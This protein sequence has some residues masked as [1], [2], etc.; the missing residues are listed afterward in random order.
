MT[1]WMENYGRHGSPWNGRNCC[2]GLED[3]CAY[4]GEGKGLTPVED[5]IRQHG[6]VT[7]QKLTA[8]Q[9]FDVN[10]IEGIVRVPE[11]FSEVASI[12]FGDGEVTFVSPSGERVT[13]SV[14]VD[15]LQ[16]G[17]IV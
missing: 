17:A 2:I 15:F 1:M 16:T 4:L 10:Y 12:E 9:P 14:E 3:V 11:G 7:R 8:E 6:V 13:A 5:A